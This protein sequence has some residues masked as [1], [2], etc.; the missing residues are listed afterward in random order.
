MTRCPGC[1]RKNTSPYCPHCGTAQNAQNPVHLLPV[2]TV[3]E[4]GG[5]PG[6]YEL[7]LALGQGGFGV[8]YIAWDLNGKSRVAVKEYYPIRC[9]RRSSDGHTVEPKEASM[10][11]TYEGGRY[12]FLMEAKMLASLEGMPS[13]VQGLAYMELNNTAYLVME[14]LDGTPLYR[15]VKAKGRM[16][17]EEFFPP[18]RN[19]MRDI[20]KLHSRMVIHRDI[21]PDNIML[22]PDGSLKLLDFGCARSMED[23]KS[24]TVAVKPGFAPVEQ[25]QSHGQGT[26]TDVYALAATIYYCLTRIIPQP[27]PERLRGDKLV[28][29]LELPEESRPALTPEEESVL[30]WALSIERRSRPGNMEVFVKHLFPFDVQTALARDTGK[31]FPSSDDGGI[32]SGGEIKEGSSAAQPEKPGAG[33]TISSGKTE[34]FGRTTSFGETTIRGTETNAF[35]GDPLQKDVAADPG[36][37]EPAPQPKK[38]L[39]RRILDFLLRGR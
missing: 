30:M 2:G 23:G 10:E 4:G 24:M 8:T 29:P 26:W 16:S 20:A 39:L 22:M 9:A 31:P 37:P 36:I 3:L 32:L 33:G 1:M 18:L 27:S 19:L 7:G 35:G 5:L 14:Y 25:Y 13:V 38:G 28:S 17:V 11:G 12:S 6:R 34:D 21:A 15:I